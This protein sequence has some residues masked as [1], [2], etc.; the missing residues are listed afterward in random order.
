M[1]I[2]FVSVLLLLFNALGYSD[3]IFEGGGTYIIDYRIR[4]Q[5]VYIDQNTL[6][7]QTHVILNPG[8]RTDSDVLCFGSSIFTLNGGY[9]EGFLNFLDTS[10]GDIQSGTIYSRLYAQEESSVAIHNVD[11]GDLLITWNESHVAIYGGTF[12]YKPS[13]T[14]QQGICAVENSL[15]TVYGGSMRGILVGH[16]DNTAFDTSTIRIFGSNFKHNGNDINYGKYYA[17]DF[18]RDNIGYIGSL[19]GTLA[20]GDS[21]HSNVYIYDG[22]CLELIPEPTTLSLL[23]LGSIALFKRKR[24]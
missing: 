4:N 12:G 3:V 24:I 15:I 7:A 8:G 23:A 2:K 5:S 6:E 1:K 21:L 19:T 10:T 13:I 11:L 20:N 18:M 17:T 16:R 22:A 9:A 14:Y